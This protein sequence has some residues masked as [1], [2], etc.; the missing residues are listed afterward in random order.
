M[1]R[2]QQRGYGT[3]CAGKRG[4]MCAH[5]RLHVQPHAYMHQLRLTYRHALAGAHTQTCAH[6][7]SSCTHAQPHA[8]KA[9][10]ASRCMALGSRSTTLASPSTRYGSTMPLPPVRSP[11]LSSSSCSR[12]VRVEI[13][14]EDQVE[15]EWGVPHVTCTRVR[16]QTSWTFI[17]ACNEPTHCLC[18]HLC[19]VAQPLPPRPWT[20]CATPTTENHTSP[21]LA[22]SKAS[23]LDFLLIPCSCAT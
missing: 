10:A 14:G 21:G 17:T 2:V 9:A 5:H 23:F 8:C 18:D 7:A 3:F 1:C 6:K 16:G 22:S 19:W 4:S 11:A 12:G 13:R 20:V 15:R